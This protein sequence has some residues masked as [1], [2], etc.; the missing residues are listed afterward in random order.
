M[1][2]L[3]YSHFL[4]NTTRPNYSCFNIMFGMKFKALIKPYITNRKNKL[5]DCF[6]YTVNVVKMYSN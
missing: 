3:K 1:F 4:H 2:K 6:K 5:Q